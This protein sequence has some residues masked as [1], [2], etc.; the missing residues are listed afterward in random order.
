MGFEDKIPTIAMIGCQIL[1]SAVA[2]SGRA[3]LLD[4][5]SSKV[6]VVYRQCFA[7]FLIAPLAFFSRRG[8]REYG[9]GWKSFG[10]I[11]LLSFIGVTVN[12]NMYYE[13]LQLGTSSAASSITNLV[14]AITFI[15]AYTFGLEEVNWRSL[16][17]GAK[18]VG[19]IVCVC[20][21]AA[22]A[23]LKGPKLLINPTITNLSLHPKHNLFLLSY[24]QE[25]TWLLGCSYLFGSTFCWSLWLILQVHLSASYSDHIA[26]TAWICLIAAVQSAIWTFMVEPDMN[27][28]K[29]TSSFQ[30]FSCFFAG[31]ASAATLYGQAWCTT[32][33][34]PLFAAL[35][36]PLSTL[37]VTTIACIF[38]QEQ[39][40]FG[41]LMG[42][43]IVIIGLYIVLWGKA[44]E[45]QVMN[46]EENDS[47]S[48]LTS[49]I[50][51]NCSENGLEDPL[52]SKK[53][54]TN[55]DV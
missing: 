44:T 20:G 3:V 36:N 51:C 19:T 8:K 41:G 13:G 11:S 40:Y 9:L 37:I 10:M 33:R 39:L 46:N 48:Q 18:V 29:L 32:R 42:G 24:G 47:S 30:L 45:H 31:L 43:M 35:F 2:L 23:L 26:S 50:I 27:V 21:A 38:M 54:P 6:F 25:D 7:F 14:P 52:L 4:G 53:D 28:W 17:S 16:R 12:Q 49:D 34:G 5:L 22:M 55:L 15:M 1:Y